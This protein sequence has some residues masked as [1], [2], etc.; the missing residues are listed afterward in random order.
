MRTFVRLYVL[1][2]I[3]KHSKFRRHT[4]KKIKRDRKS[5]HSHYNASGN[6]RGSLYGCENGIDQ[7]VE[8]ARF[9]SQLKLNMRWHKRMVCCHTENLRTT[10]FFPIRFQNHAARGCFRRFGFSAKLLKWQPSCTGERLCGRRKGKITN[11]RAEVN[12]RTSYAIYFGSA[13]S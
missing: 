6:I 13:L 4:R 12:Y 11:A 3:R 1:N 5:M 2:E 7:P 10:I 8:R 9:G